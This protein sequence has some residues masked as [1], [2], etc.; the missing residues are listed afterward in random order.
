MEPPRILV[1]D[2]HR[3]FGEGLALLLREGLGASVELAETFAAGLAR[4]QAPPP[5]SLVVLDIELPD[6]NGLEGVTRLRTAA[7]APPVVVVSSHASPMARDTALARGAAAYV[8]KAEQPEPLMAALRA[9]MRGMRPSQPLESAA[10][11]AGFTL[12][13]REV[14]ILLAEGKSN[15][16]IAR[17]LAISE[18]TVR[19]YVAAILD[20]LGVANRHEAARA[21]ARLG[22]L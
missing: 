13:Q 4:L 22:L 20:R 17:Q 5:V 16:V 19:N 14:L 18:N 3:L 12:R 10:A 9:V 15:K 6:T 7:E 2:D 1:I 21:A 11:G 8:S